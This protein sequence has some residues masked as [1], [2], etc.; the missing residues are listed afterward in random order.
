MSTT[1]T[2]S[3]V[4]RILVTGASGFLATHVVAKALEA[5]YAVRGTVRSTEKGNAIQQRYAHLGN[6]FDIVVV[7]DLVTGD[8]SEALK[9]ISAVIHVAS[10]FTGVVR[11]PKKDMLDPAIEGTLNVVRS[12]HEAGIKRIIV[13]SSYV[14]VIDLALGG[15]W[16]DYTYTAND[17]NPATYEQ[18]I[19]GDKPGIWVYCASKKLAEVAAFDYAKAHPELKITTIHPPLIFGPPEQSVSSN[20]TL[21][22]SSQAIYRLISGEAKTVPLD[23]LPLFVDVRDA[24]QAH[25]LALKNDSVAGKRV[26]LSGG[27]YSSYDA[28]KLIAEKRPELKSRLPSLEGA[29]PDPRPIANV[30]TSIAE[31]LGLS[32]TSYETCLLDTIDVLLQREHKEWKL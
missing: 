11:D 7:E 28:V 18:A 9:G 31:E 8:L 22:T 21:N 10:P 20:A 5:G 4:P 25:I 30:D 13:T 1:S 24:A 6:K 15:A 26:L 32:F 3:D 23:S 12:T 2:S 17:W 27:S 16:R 19:K 14:A 29:Q